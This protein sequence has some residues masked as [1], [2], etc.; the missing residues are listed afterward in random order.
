MCG[1]NFSEIPPELYHFRSPAVRSAVDLLEAPHASLPELAAES[2]PFLLALGCCWA[3]QVLTC[4]PSSV[5]LAEFSSCFNRLHTHPNSRIAREGSDTQ[6]QIVVNLEASI[7][8]C[9]QSGSCLASP[10]PLA[11]GHR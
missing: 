6:K 3:A 11:L 8:C 1:L 4:L 9:P 7:S 5:N 2:S 10:F